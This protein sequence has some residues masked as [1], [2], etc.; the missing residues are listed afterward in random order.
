MRAIQATVTS[1]SDG[2]TVHVNLNGRDERV[3]MIGVNCPEISHPDLGI[4]EEPY[5]R[6]AKAYTER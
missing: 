5:G 4:K 2:D 1:I 3:R 6:E